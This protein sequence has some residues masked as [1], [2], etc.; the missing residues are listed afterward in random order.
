[1]LISLAVRLLIPDTT[2]ST[3]RRALQGHGLEG[4][5]E[6]RRE[7]GWSFVV[8]AEQPALVAALAGRLIAADVLVNQN[9]ERARWWAGPLDAATSPLAAGT[10]GMQ[11]AAVLVED[12]DDGLI[13]RM[14]RLL[15]TRLGF[16]GLEVARHGT[17]WWV[18]APPDV[19]SVA[20]LA[21]ERLLANPHGQTYAVLPGG[22]S[23]VG[24][25]PPH[26]G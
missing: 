24:G 9:K 23:P 11:W 18:G 15:T 21:A 26:A 8:E 16:E 7:V 12:R 13:A 20:R 5:A 3:A 25:G 19:D 14:Q 1:M 10:G 22:P 2:A 17:L 4:L 6:L